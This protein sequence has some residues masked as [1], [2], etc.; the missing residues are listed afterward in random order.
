MVEVAEWDRLNEEA[1]RRCHEERSAAP[2]EELIQLTGIDWCEPSFDGKLPPIPPCRNIDNSVQRLPRRL[3]RNAARMLNSEDH[4][5][6]LE[7]LGILHDAELETTL[8]GED[9]RLIYI[10]YLMTIA[11][12]FAVIHFLVV[13][14]R[15]LTGDLAWWADL[16][17]MLGL[18]A[19]LAAWVPLHEGEPRS[20]H[21][22]RALP[23]RERPS[24][25]PTGPPAGFGA[26]GQPIRS[27]I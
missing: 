15:W 18:L 2:L 3:R 8:I 4:C 12:G 16:I 24:V 22:R 13:M 7:V 25:V 6:A 19:M 23:V 14:F 1:H 26:T 9:R 20:P 11:F 10:E 17:A 27:A 21:E 5:G